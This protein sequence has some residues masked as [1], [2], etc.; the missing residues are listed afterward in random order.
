MSPSSTLTPSQPD[1]LAVLLQ[2][3]DQLI[4]LLD[5]VMILL[6]LVV[7][8]VRL[9]DAVDSVDGASNTACC[10]ELRQISTIDNQHIDQRFAIA[11]A[12]ICANN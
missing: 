2:L 11:H 12:N 9:D 10:N 3:G 1:R 5:H 6:V 7:R 4:A 8:P